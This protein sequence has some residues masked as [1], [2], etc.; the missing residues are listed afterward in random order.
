[1]IVA[2]LILF[3]TMIV[4]EFNH[5]YHELG[6]C[7]SKS[8]QSLSHV[9]FFAIPCTAACQA[10]MSV[11]SSQNLLKLMSIRSMMPSNHL[12]LCRPFLLPPSVF[13]SI[14]IFPMNQFFTSGGPEFW[15]LI[16]FRMDCLD[17]LAG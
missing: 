5:V 1:M 15:R 3:E 17:L 7:I 14:R 9:Q 10:S 8:V 4:C 2:Q 6:M 16:S 11:T 12:I 13:P